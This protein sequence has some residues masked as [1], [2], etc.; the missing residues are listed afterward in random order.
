MTAKLVL[1]LED[2]MPWGKH[3]DE[4]IEDL[5]YD[6]PD[7]IQWLCEQDLFEWAPDAQAL[8]EKQKLI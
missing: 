7:F 8:I 3:Q 2:H 4:Q 1:G 5:I 6:D